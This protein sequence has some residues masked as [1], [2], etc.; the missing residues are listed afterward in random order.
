[1][2]V[3]PLTSM[4]WAQAEALYRELTNGPDIGGVENFAQVLT[5]PG[6]RIFGLEEKESIVSMVTLHLL[7]NVT[8]GGRPY[9]LIENVITLKEAR[10][11]GLGRRVLQHAIDAAWAEDAYKLMLLTGQ[12]RGAKGFYEALGFSSDGKWGMTLR[13]ISPVPPQM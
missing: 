1:M 13:R 8:Y 2:R 11:Q 12:A 5:H 3:R 9:G 7:P 4:D 10:N 6:T